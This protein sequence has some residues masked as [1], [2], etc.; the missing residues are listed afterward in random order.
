MASE[1][2]SYIVD[3]GDGEIHVAHVFYGKTRAIAET[4][5]RHHIQSCE[6]FSAAVDEGR[7]IQEH[8]EI[9][10]DDLPTAAADDGRPPGRV[11]DVTPE[12][13]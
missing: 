7:E 4:A 1:L 9:S 2:W 11:I 5:R 12:G 8:E 3:A 6:Y 10:D 13:K